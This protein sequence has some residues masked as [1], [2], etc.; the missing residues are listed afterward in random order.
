MK[1]FGKK[2]TKLV[3]LASDSV[4]LNQLKE[5]H[6]KLELKYE[7]NKIKLDKKIEELNRDKSEIRYIEEFRERYNIITSNLANI[8]SETIQIN[9]NGE[10]S[11]EDEEKELDRVTS[12]STR[13]R[14]QNIFS[15]TIS[16]LNIIERDIDNEISLV[17]R[18]RD[19]L[20]RE[21]ERVNEDIKQKLRNVRDKIKNK[22][23]SLF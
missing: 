13:E 5:R 3:N 1:A 12:L 15:D 6:K 21:Y 14:I 7:K 8:S 19:E 16:K 17:L 9:N 20:D 22:K 4:D 18:E 11:S 23:D 10:Q 2:I